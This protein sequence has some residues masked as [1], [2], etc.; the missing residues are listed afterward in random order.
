MSKF[1]EK[2]LAV[3]V[4]MQL[5]LSSV[6]SAFAQE[7]LIKVMNTTAGQP[8]LILLRGEPKEVVELTITNPFHSVIT[9]SYQLNDQGYLQYWYAKTTMAGE[10]ILEYKDQITSFTVLPAA[11][12]P[13]KSQIELNDYTAFVGTNMTGK[14]TLKDHYGNFVSGRPLE[15]KTKGSTRIACSN[16]CRTNQKGIVQFSLSADQAGMKQLSVIDSQTGSMIFQ[17]DL[18]FIPYV[19]ASPQVIRSNSTLPIQYDSPLPTGQFDFIPILDPFRAT[20]GSQGNDDRF[21]SNGIEYRF[22]SYLPAQLLDPTTDGSS[23]SLSAPS[24]MESSSNSTMALSSSSGNIASFQ[25]IFGVD[26]TAVYKEQ[27]EVEANKALDFILRAVDAQGNIVSAFNSDVKFTLDPAGPLVPPDYTFK[28]IDQGEAVFELALVLPAGQYALSVED[29][30]NPNVKG[31]VNITA[32]LESAPTLN[33]TTIALTVD[34]PVANSVYS[35]TFAVQGSTNTDNTEILIREGATELKRGRVDE[36]KKYSFPLQL[37]D[38]H[39]QLE[40]SATYLVD[41]SQTETTVDFDIDKTAPI[42]TSIAIQSEAVRSGEPF[43]ITAVAEVNSIMKA[44]INNRAYDFIGIGTDYTLTANAPL[45]QGDFPVNIQ[46]ADAL[47]NSETSNNAGILKVIAALEEIKNISGT[48]GVGSVTLFWD[49]VGSAATYELQYKSVLGVSSQT[50][51]TDTSRKIV[52]NLVPDV[53]YVFTVKAKDVSGNNLSLATDSRA[54]QVLSPPV[55]TTVIT[56]PPVQEP[57]LRPA[58]QVQTLP[59]RHTKSGPEV[60]LLILL[61]VIVLNL[62]GRVRKAFANLD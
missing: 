57:E 26:K 14:L 42:I 10:Y 25:I 7:S 48:P 47:G 30:T 32:R 59:E 9:Q 11:P 50:I 38:G 46:I 36:Q 39:H 33:N 54:L 27:A 44:F 49:P 24:T 34:S 61:S 53:S 8:A 15:L 4:I 13:K 23:S 60:Y 21:L 41:G 56:P 52:E 45:D 51:T 6:P 12:D 62:Y 37:M 58:A 28:P 55:E 1:L 29:K 20:M 31:A 16:G 35:T 40:I 22:N 19:Q 43:T 2:V 5:V 18:G 3:I 17:E